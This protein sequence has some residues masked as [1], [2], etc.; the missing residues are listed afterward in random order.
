[1]SVAAKQC[2]EYLEATF[3]GIRISRRSC[4]DTVGGSISQHSAY[5]AGEY[6]SNALDIMG[7]EGG[8]WAEN[9][10]L[11]HRVVG[12]LNQWR[13]RWSIRLILWQ[14]PDHFGHAHIDFWPTLIYPHKWCGGPTDP[15]WKLSNGATVYDRIPEPENG[16]FDWSI[17]PRQ[18]WEQMIDAL[19]EGR[20]DMFRGDP[21]YWKTLDPNSPEWADFFAAMVKAISLTNE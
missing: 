20:P 6:D 4:R 8:N 17:M 10:A 2:R 15:T 5:E 1:M 7:V 18:Q 19:F 3:P 11:I 12:D 13:D 14:V 16:R 9:V 21:D